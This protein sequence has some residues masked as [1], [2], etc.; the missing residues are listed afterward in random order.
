M[1]I[2]GDAKRFHRGEGSK[3]WRQLVDATKLSQ[4]TPAEIERWKDRYVAGHRG[5]ALKQ[6]HAMTTAQSILRNSKALF[7]SRVRRK[8]EQAKV[9]LEMPSH[10]DRKST[11][12]T[13]VTL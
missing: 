10:G 9:E 3:L 13:P 6:H 1:E 12:R 5:D 7:S 4:L 2:E 11:R 8:L